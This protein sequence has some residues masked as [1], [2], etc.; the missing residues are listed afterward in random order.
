MKSR[1][2]IPNDLNVFIQVDS[3]GTIPGWQNFIS[4]L[5]LLFG[6]ISNLLLF[7][8]LSPL[9]FAIRWGL[10]SS[11]GFSGTQDSFALALVVLRLHA[12]YFLSFT[13]QSDG[14]LPPQ[15]KDV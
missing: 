9:P 1:W 11:P 10:G 15:F 2:L 13:I 4:K 14:P 7:C 8:F 12:Y 6:F 5:C 3:V